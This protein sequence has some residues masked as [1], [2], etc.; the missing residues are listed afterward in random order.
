MVSHSWL[1][2]ARGV[3]LSLLLLST[4]PLGQAVAVPPVTTAKLPAVV[5]LRVQPASLVLT[6]ARDA[7][8][9]LVSGRTA[10]GQWID[11][12]REAKLMPAA[13]VTVDA[14]GYIAP[15]KA[16]ATKVVVAAGGRKIELP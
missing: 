8:R 13:G 3:S 6:N 12:S 5:A 4:L 15:V 7:R 16:G 2:R 1:P 14:D 10:S 9:V 11:L